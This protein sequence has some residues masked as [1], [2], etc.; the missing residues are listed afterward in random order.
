MSFFETINEAI[1]DEGR[2]LKIKIG[3]KIVIS[4]DISFS[5]SYDYLLLEGDFSFNLSEFNNITSEEFP[6]LSDAHIYF[7]RIK[8]LCKYTFSE[9]SDNNVFQIIQPN[10]TL[11]EIIG[12]IFD[13]KIS[14]EQTP[15]FLEIRLYTN[16]NSNKAPRVF[17]FIGSCGIVYILCYDPFHQIYNKTGKI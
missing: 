6:N 2:D 7:K 3:E 14:A 17:G 8:E 9:L 4:Q 12:H 10:K 1:E 15:P 11:R 16:K 5:V 13:K